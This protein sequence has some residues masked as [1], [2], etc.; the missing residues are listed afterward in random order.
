MIGNVDM[1]DPT[2]NGITQVQEKLEGTQLAG[3][4]IIIIIPR[5]I[6]IVLSS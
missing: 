4:I 1:A 6:F 3:L 2:T 5:T